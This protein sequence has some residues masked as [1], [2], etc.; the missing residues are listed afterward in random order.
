M[1]EALRTH[2]GIQRA[3]I[4]ELSGEIDRTLAITVAGGPRYVLKIAGALAEEAELRVQLAMLE[5]IARQDPD[6]PTPRIVRTLDGASSGSIALASGQHHLHLLTW[7]DGVRLADVTWHSD[8]LL[9]E[10]GSAAARVVNDLA[11]FSDPA[12]D[13][14]HLW[15]MRAVAEI[16]RDG[17]EAVPDPLDREAVER[18]LQAYEDEAR[19]RLAALPQGTV[20]QDLNDYNVL[21]RRDSAGALGLAGILDFG[22]AL[23]SARVTE[24]AVL[25]A[26][27]MLRKPDP[28]R[29]ARAVVAGFHSILPLDVGELAALFPMAAARVCAMAVTWTRRLVDDPQ[30]L[31]ATRRS[32]DAWPLVRQLAALPPTLGV[33]CVRAAAGLEP[34]P[35]HDAVVQGVRDA[36]PVPP[37]DWAELSVVEG[38]HGGVRL[39]RGGRRASGEGEPDTVALGLEVHVESGAEV[40]AP[41]AG[42]VKLASQGVLVLHHGSLDAGGCGTI[43]R[44]LT[45]VARSGQTVRPGDIVGTAT[46]VTPGEPTA[47]WIQLAC[48]FDRETTPPKFARPSEAAMWLS[49]CPDPLSLLFGRERTDQVP[50]PVETI[51]ATREQRFARSQ[52]SYY[53]RPMNL[54]EAN[55]VWFTDDHGY[56]YLDALNNV[57]HVGH[58][59]PRV[60]EAACRQLQRLNT[61]SRFVYGQL[62]E[63]ADRL[64]RL[65]PAPLEVIFLV[66]TGSEANDLAARIARQVTGRDTMLVI[67]GAYHG[68]TAAV[69]ALSPNRYKGPGGAGTPSTTVEIPMPDRYRGAYGYA[70]DC[71][72]PH[73]AADAAAIIRQSV[74]AGRPP[75]ALLAESLMGSGGQIVY[76]PGYLREVF[77]SVRD[78]GGLC[79]S[80]EVQVG[81]GRLGTDHF[82]GFEFHDVVPDIV[83]MGKPIG[84][85]YPMAA[86]ATT[87][88]IA[89][90]FDTGMRYFNTFGGNPV[91][92]AV[93]MAVLDVIEDEGLQ[94]RAARVGAEFQAELAR[95]TARHEIIGDIRGQ[96]M[97]LGIELVSDRVTRTPAK[98]E[99]YLISERMKDEG[100][101]VYPNGVLDNVLKIKPPLVFGSEHVELFTSTLDRILGEGW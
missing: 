27:T 2:Y 44:G 78:A 76:P 80:D 84:N 81:F 85:G 82:W 43:F 16:V 37:L 91:A 74:A 92:C 57:T 1:L 51:V 73:Y 32:G 75:A 20:H 71:A 8:S 24:L 59:H 12:L 68:N 47:V 14:T 56:Q 10:L 90:A 29:A 65:L 53:R 61:N 35:R 3:E 26:N 9:Q 89:E 41:M 50:P 101:I 11:D 100:V 22:D 31:Y 25:V 19:P 67:D 33:A 52:R 87:R 66:C 97:Y 18:L 13:R 60:V 70:D 54:V 88:E 95:L 63:Y 55:G 96:G 99:A 98:Q 83:T 49:A 30:N 15:D 48:D 7:I 39:Q 23:R 28:L 93:G 34:H 5:H 45:P 64:A 62:P 4:E 58:G 77:A 46:P 94:E 79:I 21:V 72:G 6:L 86:V 69:T 38:G 17:L 36:A 42:T 40:R